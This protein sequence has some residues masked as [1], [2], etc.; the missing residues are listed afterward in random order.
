MD[1]YKDMHKEIIETVDFGNPESIEKHYR[2]IL[3]IVARILYIKFI[4]GPLAPYIKMF[5]LFVLVLPSKILLKFNNNFVLF[6][7]FSL[8]SN[9]KNEETS[10]SSDKYLLKKIN[11]FCVKEIKQIEKKIK[12]Q[13]RQVKK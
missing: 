1:I 11:N 3:L 10:K 4:K 6:L 2:P 12:K 8:I 5:I 13:R 7:Y 9:V